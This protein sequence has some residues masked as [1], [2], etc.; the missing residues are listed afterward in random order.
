[1]SISVEQFKAG[2][3]WSN[4]GKERTYKDLPFRWSFPSGD[5]EELLGSTPGNRN[6]YTASISG[7]GAIWVRRLLEELCVGG[8][9]D[10]V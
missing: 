9:P 2:H 6:R 3:D 5:P 8:A 4:L 1:M 7:H 10:T